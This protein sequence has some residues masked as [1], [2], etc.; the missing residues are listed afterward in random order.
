MPRLVIKNATMKSQKY[1]IVF[2][3]SVEL[4]KSL[5]QQKPVHF[6]CSQGLL[7]WPEDNSVVIIKMRHMPF[8][9]KMSYVCVMDKLSLRNQCCSQNCPVRTVT[10]VKRLTPLSGECLFFIRSCCNSEWTKRII[11]WSCNMGI[12]HVS[13]FYV[14][15]K[16][17]IRHTME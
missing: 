11:F 13:P 3:F 15:K 1:P 8:W 5:I 12:W 9:S 4:N 17:D 10:T 6:S 2:Y 7:H 14:K 16:G